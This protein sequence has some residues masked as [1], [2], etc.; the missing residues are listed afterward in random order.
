M[1]RKLEIAKMVKASYVAKYGTLPDP[2]KFEEIAEVWEIAL[3]DCPTEDID[4][5]RRDTIKSGEF[6]LIEHF[7][8]TW[9]KIAEDRR[10]DEMARLDK[11][12]TDAHHKIREDRMAGVSER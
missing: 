10:Y 11:E 3:E 7:R 12:R 9:D 6:T 2:D 8:A 4:R 5:V 1:V